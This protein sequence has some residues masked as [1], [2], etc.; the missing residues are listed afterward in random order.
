MINKGGLMHLDTFLKQV[1]VKVQGEQAYIVDETVIT[2]YP[3]TLYVNDKEINTF[4]CTPQNLEEL[5]V[6]YLISCDMLG[7]KKDILNLEIVNNRNIAK[8]VLAENTNCKKK[9]KFKKTM[10]V[11]IQTIYQIMR[12]NLKPTNLFME[13]GGF[14]S[15]AIFDEEKE[16]I[17]IMDVARHNAVDKVIGHCMLNNIDCS[18]KILVVSGRISSNMLVK[19]V[20]GNIPIVLSKSAPTSLSIAI[21]DKAGI[22]LVGFVRG[23]RM[24]VYTHPDRI[25]L[26]EEILRTISKK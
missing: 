14:H 16:V 7:D 23:E 11:K 5:V 12:T 26:D 2:E 15:V 1:V 25:D 8:I 6:G 9:M 24:N 20:K 18:D 22:T 21:A 4:Y 10:V 13:T 19:A 17:T 3:L